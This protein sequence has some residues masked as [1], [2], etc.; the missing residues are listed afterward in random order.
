MV[1]LEAIVMVGYPNGLWDKTNNLP[2]F[3]KGVLASDYKYDWNGK[4]EFLIDALCFPDPVVR[5]SCYLKWE[6]TKRGTP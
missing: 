5:L 6:A 3:R 4:K 2:I 1:G